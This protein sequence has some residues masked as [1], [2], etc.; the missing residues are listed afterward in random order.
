MDVCK[1]GP[2][3]L[4]TP[5]FLLEVIGSSIAH[6]CDRHRKLIRIRHAVTRA[7]FSYVLAE[8]GPKLRHRT[9]RAEIGGRIRRFFES[10][11]ALPKSVCGEFLKLL[12]LLNRLT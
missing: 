9:K 7:G 4:A 11:S 2:R 10:A 5:D 8:C 6:C 1:W 12:R 3:R